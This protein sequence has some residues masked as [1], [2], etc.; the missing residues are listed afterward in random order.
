MSTIY[1]LS[2][3]VARQL[4]TEVEDGVDA[5]RCLLILLQS[6]TFAHRTHDAFPVHD[7]E[8][9]QLWISLPQVTLDVRVK[10]P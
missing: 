5:T 8:V 1:D 9:W 3:L 10:L 7:G 2:L 4:L 6:L